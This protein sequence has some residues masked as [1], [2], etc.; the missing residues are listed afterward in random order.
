MNEKTFEYKANKYK[1]KYLY[2]KQKLTGGV[3]VTPG[4]SEDYKGECTR[5]ILL[6]SSIP[7]PVNIAE[8]NENN[9]P[10]ALCRS[11][12][13]IDLLEYSVDT[14]SLIELS[15]LSVENAVIEIY[16]EIGLKNKNTLENRSFKLDDQGSSSPV[17]AMGSYGAVFR[18]KCIGKDNCQEFICV[19]YGIKAK[20]IKADIKNIKLLKV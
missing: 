15:P 1:L 7:I 5:R 6:E 16:Y 12:Q 10:K 3:C 20:N 18:Y 2:E 4:F 9:D 17:I 8:I 19:K 14:S 13:Y 11:K